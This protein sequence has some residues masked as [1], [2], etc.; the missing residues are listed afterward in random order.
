MRVKIQRDF[1]IIGFAYGYIFDMKAKRFSKYVTLLK[2]F[3]IIVPASIGAT[4]LG[5]GIDS[6]FLK[7]ILVVAVPLTIGQLM[8]SI[9]AVL[10]KWDE[11]LAYAYEASQD[12]NLMTDDFKK[13]GDLPPSGFIELDIEYELLN[14]RF[15]ARKQQNS[16]HN[17]REWENRMGMRYAL[18]QYQKSCVGCD[19]IPLSMESTNCPVCGNFN[20]SLTFKIFKP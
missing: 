8:V 13:L 20:K 6:N 10:N 15:K 17:I 5:Y 16:K 18:R 14:T 19:S 7:L 1:G 11:E 3:G 2:V 9:F 4:A 12:L